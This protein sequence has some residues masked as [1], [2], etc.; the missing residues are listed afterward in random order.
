MLIRQGDQLS[1][2]RRY[3]L[4]RSWIVLWTALFILIL[5]FWSKIGVGLKIVGLCGLALTLP[6]SIQDLWRS[7]ESYKKEW[8][9]VNHR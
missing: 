2:R 5:V 4:Y 9:R 6:D 1:S 8:E 3:N 7:Y